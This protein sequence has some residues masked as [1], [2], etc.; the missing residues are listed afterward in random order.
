MKVT[1][2]F[3]LVSVLE[4]NTGSSENRVLRLNHNDGGG[5]SQG[6]GVQLSDIDKKSSYV[7]SSL[8]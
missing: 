3:F 4:E 8:Q 5:E 7:T 6:H 1:N 2:I